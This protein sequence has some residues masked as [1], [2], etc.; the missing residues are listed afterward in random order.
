MF[1]SVNTYR[2]PSKTWPD[3]ATRILEEN[4]YTTTEETCPSQFYVPGV[5]HEPKQLSIG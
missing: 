2:Q 3:C 5:T 4:Q 1:V